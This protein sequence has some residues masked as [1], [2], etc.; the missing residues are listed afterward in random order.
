MLSH[1]LKHLRGLL[2]DSDKAKQSNTIGVRRVNDSGVPSRHLVK[3]PI[4]LGGHPGWSRTANCCGQ[5]GSETTVAIHRTFGGHV[6]IS[7]AGGV[8]VVL[9]G[10]IAEHVGHGRRARTPDGHVQ[11]VGVERGEQARMAALDTARM[12]GCVERRVR[13]GRRRGEE[14]LA[15]EA[16]VSGGADL[17]VVVPQ[18]REFLD[19]RR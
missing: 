19:G 18:R 6:V 15:I 8:V 12:P 4:E 14:E 2:N 5:H 10:A 1:L 16:L 13:E 9:S 7:T 3:L 17:R 11:R